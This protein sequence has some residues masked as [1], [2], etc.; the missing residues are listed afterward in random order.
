MK[1]VY[2]WDKTNENA[3]ESKYLIGGFDNLDQAA[4]AMSLVQDSEIQPGDYD[5]KISC[6]YDGGPAD[7]D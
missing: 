2:Y 3:K 6:V 7:P 4:V 1:I 5:L